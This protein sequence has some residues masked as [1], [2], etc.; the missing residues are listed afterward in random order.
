MGRRPHQEPYCVGVALDQPEKA[1]HPDGVG[2]SALEHVLAGRETMP[3]D[4]GLFLP[5]TWRMLPTLT[6]FT[7][8]LFYEGK[9]AAKDGL[10]RQ[11]L[12]G[13]DAHA[14]SKLWMIPVLH[15]GN[16]SASD[17]EV[18]AVASLVARLLAPGSMWINEMGMASQLT[19]NDLRVVAPF[20]AQVNRLAERLS[21]LGVPVG[22]VDKFQGQTCATSSTRWRRRGRRMRRGGWSSSIV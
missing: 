13:V 14:G 3:P 9:L 18:E 20:D 11:I 2:M 8:E 7:S 19:R 6:A 5:I 17:E 21:P 15:D 22:T 4:R 1:S 12:S 10:E 16:Q